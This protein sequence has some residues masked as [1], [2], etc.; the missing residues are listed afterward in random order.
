MMSPGGSDVAA[1]LR[2]GNWVV[3][4]AL[5]TISG[6]SGTVHLEPKVMDVLGYLATRPGDVVTKEEVLA[7]VWG[8]A[9]VVEAVLTRAVS[10]LRHAFGDDARAASYI[11]TIPKRGYRLIAPVSPALRPADRQVPVRPRS[12]AVLPFRALS[13]NGQQEHVADAV[14][15]LLITSLSTLPSLRVTSRTSVMRYKEPGK[16]LSEI[17]DELQVAF[18]VE[19]SVL[20]FGEKTSL[21][22]QLIDGAADSHLWSREYRGAFTEILEMQ[23]DVARAIAH[24]MG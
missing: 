2:I 20:S 6:R 5:G 24:E 16:L 9:S 8:G 15:E 19:G 22:V 14:T 7:T 18:V 21:V 11:Q 17:A 10:Q 12:V 3:E 13:S 23:G 4:L 1:V